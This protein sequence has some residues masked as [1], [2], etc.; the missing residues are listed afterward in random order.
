[1][2]TQV[3]SELVLDPIGGEPATIEEWTN[4]FHLALVIVDPF[5]FESAWVLDQAGEVLRGFAEADCRT[6]WVVAGTEANAKQ[7]LGPCADEFLTFAD[8]DRKIVKAFEIDALPAFVMI[9]GDHEVEAAADGWDPDEWQDV[10]DR[11]A[12]VMSWSAPVIARMGGP[13]PFEGS[14]AT[15]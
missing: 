14:T 13:A 8:P 11:L 9:N 1:M 15:G 10:A 2:S 3:S 12:V 7:F 6:G 4:T 5:T